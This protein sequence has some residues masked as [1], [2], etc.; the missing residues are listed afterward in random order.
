MAADVGSVAQYMG[1]AIGVHA[2]HDFDALFMR[3]LH[4]QQPSFRVVVDIVNVDQLVMDVAQKHEIGNVVG[5]KRRPD[6]IAA[7]SRRRIG[8]DVGYKAEI[9]ASAPE[10]RSPIRDLLHPGYRQWPPAFAHRTV[11]VSWESA[12]VRVPFLR[13]DAGFFIG[14]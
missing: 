4:R 7:R 10:T 13:A 6:G 2:G 5:E 11:R 12:L 9:F 1:G 8:D 14:R 3:V